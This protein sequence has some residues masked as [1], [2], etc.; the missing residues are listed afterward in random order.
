MRAAP[1]LI[2]LSLLVACSKPATVEP[3][4]TTEPD[5]TVSTDS[6]E[7]T[8]P[9]NPDAPESPSDTAAADA[10][11][12]LP[13]SGRAGWPRAPGLSNALEPFRAAR[14]GALVR[15]LHEVGFWHA[16]LQPNNILVEEPLRYE[17]EPALWVV[18]LDRSTHGAPLAP[19]DRLANLTRL[20]RFVEHFFLGSDLWLVFEDAGVT[21]HDYAFAAAPGS[22]VLQPSASW[23]AL[24][25]SP[26]GPAWFRELARQLLETAAA[27]HASGAVHRDLKLSNVALSLV[28]DGDLS[29]SSVLAP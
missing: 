8:A 7:D 15:E 29:S 22:G 11:A 6:A 3:P 4:V 14:L 25:T 18:D 5:T 28:N 21:L 12:R 17:Q 10:G 9:V 2:A 16:D 13:L 19:L 27:L 23:R 1:L 20:V 26:E 24:R